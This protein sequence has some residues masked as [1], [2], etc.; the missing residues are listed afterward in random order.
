MNKLILSSLLIIFSLLMLTCRTYPCRKTVTSDDEVVTDSIKTYS[1]NDSI[2]LVMDKNAMG[3]YVWFME[4][5]DSIELVEEIDSTYLNEK[6]QLNEHA[7]IF[8]IKPLE[9]GEINIRFYQKRDFEPDSLSIKD[10]YTEK[11]IIK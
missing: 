9:I 10:A 8:V 5:N 11:L 2:R 3:G 6:T 4:K 1:L 7:K